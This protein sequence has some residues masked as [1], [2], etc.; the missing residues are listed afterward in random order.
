MEVYRM[1]REAADARGDGRL[2]SVRVAVG[3]LSAVEPDLL[4]F[5]WD[6]VTAGGPDAG[7][8]LVIERHDARQICGACGEVAER[9]AG[10]WLRLCPRCDLPLRVEGGDELDLLQ[11]EFAGEEA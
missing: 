11:I 5:A 8:R 10:S 6:A 9:A 1:S 3:E 7:S 2:V 4:S